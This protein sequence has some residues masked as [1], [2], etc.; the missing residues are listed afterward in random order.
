MLHKLHRAQR[1]TR[2]VTLAVSDVRSILFERSS[3]WVHSQHCCGIMIQQ[4]RASVVTMR[5]VKG[6]RAWT[7]CWIRMVVGSLSYGKEG[8]AKVTKEMGPGRTNDRCCS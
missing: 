7:S 1:D 8:R 6:R 4:N 5:A 3:E 2:G